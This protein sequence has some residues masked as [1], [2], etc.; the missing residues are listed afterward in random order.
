PAPAGVYF[1]EIVYQVGGAVGEA[2]ISLATTADFVNFT[3]EDSVVI[4]QGPPECMKNTAPEYAEWQAWGK[5]DCWCYARQ[6][7]GDADGIKT[8]PFWV[9][10]PDLEGFRQCMNRDPMP[11]GCICYDFDH[12][13]SGPFRIAIS[14][15]TTFR[16]YFNKPEL[17]VPECDPTN[18]NFWETP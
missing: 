15:L 5:P 10:I 12:L 16:F 4:R 18:Y 14:D 3:L 17:Q 9:A 2:V 7:R 1:D 8:G 6:C 11:P 13:K